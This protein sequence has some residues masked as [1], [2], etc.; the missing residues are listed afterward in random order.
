MTD[1]T[2]APPPTPYAPA[3]LTRA[4]AEA[5]ARAG[6]LEELGVRPPM[7]RYVRD[8][9]RYRHLV[10][11]LSSSQAYATNQNNHLGQLWAVLN[12]LL[13]VGSYYLIFGL[14]LKTR[15]G[16]S[17]YIAFLTIGIFVFG[18]TAS[19]LT[20]GAR[21]VT[22]NIGLVRALRFPRAVLPVS[23][24]L[25]QFLVNVPAFLVLMVMV[26][27]TGEPF[28]W[29]WFL[30]P[31]ALGLQSLV[32][33]GLVFFLARIV[34]AARDTNNLVPVVVRLARYVSGVFF[35]IPHYAGHGLMSAVLL[36]QPLAVGMTTAREALM[37]QYP[38]SWSSW[39]AAAVWGV[40]LCASGIV[41]F[42][43]GEGRYGSD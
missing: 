5:L 39:V 35:S 13:L 29:H 2:T 17:N 41:F 10:W 31:V 34:N 33:L 28:S 32:N 16:T 18:Y 38:L 43:R 27:L 40:V 25:T 15:G 8:V 7:R 37:D 3:T 42:W 1:V 22:A 20:A 36:Y 12:P 4:Q 19:A 9:W 24:T 23:V 6:G 14:L 21:A 11:H 30:F 26:P